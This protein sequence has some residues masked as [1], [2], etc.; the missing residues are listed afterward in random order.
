QSTSTNEILWTSTQAGLNSTATRPSTNKDPVYRLEESF[1]REFENYFNRSPATKIYSQDDVR[2]WIS[3]LEQATGIKTGVIYVNFLP[4]SV[5]QSDDSSQAQSKSKSTSSSTATPSS[6]SQLPRDRR[7]GH[8][9]PEL[10]QP[11]AGSLPG[12]NDQLELLM[13]TAK[14]EPIRYRVPGSERAK[15][16]AVAQKFQQELTNPKNTNSTNYLSSAQQLYRWL[17]EPLEGELQARDIHSLVFAMDAGLRSLPLAALHDGKGFLVEKYGVSLVPTLSLTASH[18]KD[19]RSLQVLAMGASEF[20][21]QPPLPGVQLELT[22]IAEHLWRGKMLMNDRFTLN[23]LTAQRRQ[24]GYGIVHLATHA[25]FQPGAPNN[26]YIQLWDRKLR[27]NEL[28]KLQLSKPPVELL[29]LS[30]CRTALGNKDAEL[31]F[32]G[33]ALQAGVDSTLATL[34]YVSDRGALGLTTE[35]YRQ[36][37]QVP[38]KSEALRQAQLAMIKGKVRV[39]NNQLYYSGKSISLPPGLSASGNVSLSHPYYWA[40]FTLIGDPR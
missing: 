2:N 35:F 36:L 19:I 11:Q 17:I 40:A 3:Q 14:G 39:E 21:D 16:L 23:N 28:D 34:W 32:A 10:N 37:R 29:V 24:Q 25:E 9:R 20:T 12:Q 33:S 26:S 13:V 6:S 7:F 15:V 27:L 8:R 31:G 38:I 5:A 22:T 30:A 4:S 18:Q 1:T